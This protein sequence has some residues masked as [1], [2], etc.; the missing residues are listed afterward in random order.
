MCKKFLLILTLSIITLASSAQ[1]VTINLVDD[2]AKQSIL[3][4]DDT[5]SI[6]LKV[7]NIPP[8]VSDL[9]QIDLGY[10]VLSLDPLVRQT[11]TQGAALRANCP[12]DTGTNKD[13]T[14]LSEIN[15]AK[16]PSKIQ[17]LIKTA[18]ESD[19]GIYSKTCIAHVLKLTR[20]ESTVQIPTGYE[21]SVN[22]KY[23]GASVSKHTLARTTT[24]WNTHVGFSFVS[25]R[26]S[27][28]YSKAMVTDTGTTYVIAEQNNQDST[29]YSA[30]ALFTYPVYQ[31]NNTEFGWTA[32]LSA[33]SDTIAV[34]FGPSII[35][36][37]NILINLGIIYQEFDELKGIYADGMDLGATPVDSS[38]LVKS[39]F[40]PSIALT[41]GF[42][43]GE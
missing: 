41:I 9:Y 38:G 19:D 13:G 22:V 8:K 18:V 35:I 43:F 32:G 37:K 15:K 7:F 16:L 23:A 5:T 2:V 11:S 21:L 6:K 39:S 10:Q 17:S 40:K 33:S 30:S 31:T 20:S 36:K 12:D 1:D 4:L 29:L 14:F 27:A 3:I 25:N 34:L 42:K 24:D 26:G 28:Y